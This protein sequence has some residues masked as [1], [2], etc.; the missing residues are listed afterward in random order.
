MTNNH[1][2]K[3]LIVAGEASGDLHAGNLINAV[4][5]QKSE[6]NFYGMGGDMMRNAGA[7]ITHDLRQVSVIGLVEVLGRLP[8]IM[9]TMKE[10]AAS[11]SIEKPDLAILVDFPDFNIRLAEK[12]K[13]AG[14]PILWYISPQVWAWRSERLAKITR[15]IDYMM[16]ILPFEVDFYR[17]HNL[18]V[19]FVGHPLVDIVKPNSSPQE[20]RDK[21]QIGDASSTIALLPGSRNVELKLLLPHLK[22]AAQLLYQHDK[23]RQFLLPV[24]SSLDPERV[25]QLLAN[26]N[27][28]IKVVKGQAY[29]C[30][31]IADCA[32]VA[33]GTATL[34]TALIGTPEI[35]IG[36]VSWLTWRLWARYTNLPYYG[37]PNYIIGEKLITELIQYQA[38]GAGIAQAVEDLLASPAAQ[39]RLK[40]GYQAIQHRLGAGGASQNAAKIVLDILAGNDRQYVLTQ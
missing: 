37:L 24:A 8:T 31:S 15:L 12:L 40:A 11:I 23:N 14:I 20:M 19:T 39:A 10:L 34:E 9:R 21:L 30:L 17:K 6:I 2:K 28:P 4:R 18:N 7:R 3:I 1:S 27:A 13:K 33:A 38:S 25:K 26:A 22:E 5:A 36:R 29:D 16:V 35:I 32:V